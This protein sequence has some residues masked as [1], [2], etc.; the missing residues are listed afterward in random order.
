M[1]VNIV[2]QESPKLL[3]RMRAEIRVRHY[4]I[5]TASLSIK[6]LITYKLRLLEERDQCRIPRIAKVSLPIHGLGQGNENPQGS[7][8][9]SVPRNRLSSTGE[10]FRL[11][12]ANPP[13]RNAARNARCINQR[14]WNRRIPHRHLFLIVPPYSH[15]QRF[16]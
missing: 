15:S 12:A 10:L 2:T 4:S 14:I 3:D 6:V 16:A 5:R 7:L 1:K 13:T 9:P 8:N 11:Q